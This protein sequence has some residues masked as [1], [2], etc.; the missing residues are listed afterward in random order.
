MKPGRKKNYPSHLG[1]KKQPD[2]DWSKPGV[3]E[4][5]KTCYRQ[6]LKSRVIMEGLASKFGFKVTRNSI[7]AKEHRL[8]LVKERMQYV[9]NRR[10]FYPID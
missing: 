5:L 4:Y 1:P 10:W 8:G 9:S 3:T 2:A 6:G 7:I